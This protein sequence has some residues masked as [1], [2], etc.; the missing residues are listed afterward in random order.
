M[1]WEVVA[2]VFVT[3]IGD[4]IW[5]SNDMITFDFTDIEKTISMPLSFSRL[6]SR[7]RAVLGHVVLL[8]TNRKSYMGIALLPSHLTLDDLDRPRPRSLRF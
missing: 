5:E 6:I 2:Q 7:K 3:V 4:H 8:N 1:M